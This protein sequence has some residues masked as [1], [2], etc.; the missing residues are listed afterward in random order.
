MRLAAADRT[1]VFASHFEALKDLCVRPVLF[2]D[3]AFFRV[4]TVL[5]TL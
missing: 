4:V 5:Q 3:S 1:N 2:W